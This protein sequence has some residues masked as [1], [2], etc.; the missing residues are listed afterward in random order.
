MLCSILILRLKK[1]RCQPSFKTFS[2]MCNLHAC[3]LFGAWY[4]AVNK[5]LYHSAARAFFMGNG[6]VAR[7]KEKDSATEGKGRSE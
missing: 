3:V 1:C 7:Y 4:N 5:T 6:I 2:C